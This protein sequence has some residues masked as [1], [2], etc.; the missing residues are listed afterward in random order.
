[1]RLYSWEY[2]LIFLPVLGYIVYLFFYK[3]KFKY[4]ATIKY[5]AVSR[6]KQIATTPRTKL[7]KYLFVLKI[8]ALFFMILALARP[9]SGQRVEEI[10]TKG[11]DIMLALDVSGSMKAEDFKPKNRLT[12]AKKV[13]ADFIKGRKTDRIGLVVFAGESFTQCPLTLDYDII[14]EYLKQIDFGMIEDGTAIGMAIANCVNRLRYSK[15]KS[16]VI[17]LLTDGENNAGAI[18]PITAARAAEAMNIK[19][20]TVGVGKIGGA[21]IPYYH[22]IFG[23]QY[24]RNPDGTLYLTMLDEQTLKKIAQITD[25]KYFRATDARS[26]ERIYKKIDALEKT[27]IKAKQYLQYTE[28]FPPFLWIA[29]GMILCYIILDN[30]LFV[31]VP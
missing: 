19:I 15:A 16:K 21:P 2:L 28:S 25:G 1:M 14:L 13:L 7:R 26:L 31:K 3:R 11:I 20:Y 30:I 10:E 22:P 24:Y 8:A 6:L 17:I 27:K 18:D 12:V 29:I 9:Q 23:K 5:P 4:Y